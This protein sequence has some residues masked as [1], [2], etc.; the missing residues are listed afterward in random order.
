MIEAILKIVGLIVGPAIQPFIRRR[1]EAEVTI[2][3]FGANP[4]SYI[5]VK[6]PGPGGVFIQ[7]VHVD[8]PIYRVAKDE[9][10]E[11]IVGAS[12]CNVGA[13]VI[14]RPGEARD[15]PIV[16][17]RNQLGI[18]KDAPS[19]TVHFAIYWRKTSSTWLWRA[20]IW[21]MTSTHHI[22]QMED[23]ADPWH[24]VP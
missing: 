11:A 23:A 1:P 12:F 8:P 18:S 24:G 19:Q 21:I 15:L 10:A 17:R 9:S 20:P 14:L 16:G 6:N 7:E 22:K 3:K 5:H 4:Y 13:S 2:K